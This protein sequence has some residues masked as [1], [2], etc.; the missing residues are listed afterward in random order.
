MS[1]KEDVWAQVEDFRRQHVPED[2]AH[3]P[4]D[5]ISIA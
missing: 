4:L 1:W 5:M 2:L 3:L